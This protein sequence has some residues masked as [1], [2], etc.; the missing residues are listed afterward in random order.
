MSHPRGSGDPVFIKGNGTP[1]FAGV[2]E[3]IVPPSPN[4]AQ[5]M[6][7]KGEKKVFRL[8]F[9]SSDYLFPPLLSSFTLL[10]SPYD[11]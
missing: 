3:G 9:P 11:G 2:T 10:T 8:F 5:I 1:A 4:H 7:T 6:E